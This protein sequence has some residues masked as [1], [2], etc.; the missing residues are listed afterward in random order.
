MNKYKVKL[1]GY[2]EWREAEAVSAGM[3]RIVLIEQLS[4]EQGCDFFEF[5]SS[6][7]VIV[8]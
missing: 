3:A 1:D 4:R 2:S 6:V 7:R 5:Q 8:V